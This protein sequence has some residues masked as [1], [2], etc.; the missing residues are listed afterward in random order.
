ML[1]R[2]YITLKV[3]ADLLSLATQPTKIY[4]RIIKVYPMTEAA[5]YRHPPETSFLL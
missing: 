1:G 2:K 4:Q 5:L 3:A